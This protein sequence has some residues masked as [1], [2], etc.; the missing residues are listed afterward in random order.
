MAR[1]TAKKAAATGPHQLAPHLG[2]LAVGAVGVSTAVAGYKV[3]H[4]AHR[5]RAIHPLARTQGRDL[6]F[7]A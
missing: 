4:F 6:P 3:S 7:W 2:I 5:R 1:E